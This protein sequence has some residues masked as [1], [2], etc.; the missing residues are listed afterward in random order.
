MENI[1]KFGIRRLH[2]SISEPLFVEIV[3]RGYIKNIDTI[4]SELL[5]QYMNEQEKT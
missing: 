2:I 4:V 3:R 1:N 5:I